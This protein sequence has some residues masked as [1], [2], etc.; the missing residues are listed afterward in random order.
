MVIDYAPI[1]PRAW[2][3]RRVKKGQIKIDGQPGEWAKDADRYQ[4]PNWMLGPKGDK[5][6]SRIYM[7]Y[8]DDGLYMMFDLDDS[9]CKTSDPNS[10]WRAADCLEFQFGSNGDFTPDQKWSLDDHQ[11][12]F[13][14]MPL[15]N[16]VFSGF[17]P[18]CE[19]Q[20]SPVTDNK[21]GITP[22]QGITSIAVQGLRDPREV[23]WPSPKR[24]DM[25]VKKPY[26]WSRVLLGD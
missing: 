6:T 15:E 12:W 22:E 9:Q 20:K 19:G 1:V 7:A 17:W 24:G 5:E 23:Y 8:D 13:C 10:F 21:M 4:L 3:L 14:P 16:R 11:F 25:A 2:T 18:N 26:M